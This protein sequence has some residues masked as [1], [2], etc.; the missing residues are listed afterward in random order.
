[1][2]AGWIALLDSVICTYTSL[3]APGTQ[4]EGSLLVFA[5]IASIFT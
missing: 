3:R 4:V 2:A 5:L 1:M